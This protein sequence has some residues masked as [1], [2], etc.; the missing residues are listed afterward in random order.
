MSTGSG[1]EPHPGGAQAKQNVLMYPD[2]R[3][4]TERVERCDEFSLMK[5]KKRDR[6]TRPG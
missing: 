2:T 4:Q 5:R 3:L 1:I 6:Q